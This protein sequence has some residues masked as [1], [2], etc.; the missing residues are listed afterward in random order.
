M[1]GSF[2]LLF[3]QNIY[4]S[5]IKLSLSKND[6]LITSSEENLTAQSIGTKGDNSTVT[7]Y[8]TFEGGG[9]RTYPHYVT[10][11][12][13][14]YVTYSVTYTGKTN[15]LGTSLA[16]LG[17]SDNP[18]EAITWAEAHSYSF[19]STETYMTYNST[20]DLDPTTLD[21]ILENK[22]WVANDSITGIFKCKTIYH[23]SE[24]VYGIIMSGGQI[25]VSIK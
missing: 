24:K 20:G 16:S 1:S 13:Y 19:D 17:V 8:F 2:N 21:K 18:N 15:Y 12:D 3:K 6:K 7:V 10:E 25:N 14:C 11:K 22:K 9:I 23:N 5:A 4:S